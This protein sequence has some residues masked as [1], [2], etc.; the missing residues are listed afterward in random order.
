MLLG[1]YP[2]DGL[3]ANETDMPRIGADDMRLISQPLDFYCQNIYNSRTIRA[4]GQGGY[5][6]VR[7]PLGSPI[8][9]NGWPVTPECLYW[10][11]KLLYERYGLPI[12]ISESALSCRDAVSLDGEVHDPGRIDFLR[13]YLRALRR[14]IEEGV[15]VK[16]YFVWPLMDN[17]EWSQGYQ[18]RFG[19]IHIDYA[20]QKRTVKDSG[21][22]YRDCIRSNGE[23]I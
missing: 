21:R 9:A 7:P 11:P 17:F 14:A 3:Q 22:W 15:P 10:G 13:C 5:E 16:G 18:E 20:T 2:A 12:V 1:H 19:L 4:D 6:E 8:T 23:T